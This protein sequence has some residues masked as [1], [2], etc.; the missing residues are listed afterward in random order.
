M[1]T[2]KY[3]DWPRWKK[4]DWNEYKRWRKEGGERQLDRESKKLL[5]ANYIL[6]F[7]DEVRPTRCHTVLAQRP[8]STDFTL[9]QTPTGAR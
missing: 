5:K 1:E 7:P 2:R 4:Q 6:H 8:A 9:S 3:K